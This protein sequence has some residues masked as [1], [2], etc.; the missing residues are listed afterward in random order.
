[1]QTLFL[2]IDVST[3]RQP[4]TYVALESDRRLMAIGQG[5][6]LEVLAFTAGQA[7][8][9]VAIAAPSRPNQGFMKNPE[10][11]N[12]LNPIPPPTKYLNLRQAE[13]EIELAGFLLPH[14]PSR[15]EN[16]PFWVKKAFSLYR[17]LEALGY[18][19]FPTEQHPR[20]WLETHSEAGFWCLGGKELLPANTLEGRLQRQL[21]LYEQELP[22]S[23]PMR[24]FE[25]VTRFRLL[26]GILPSE[27]ILAAAELSAM[28]AAYMAWLSAF[29]PQ[30]LCHYGSKEEGEIL[31]PAP[32]S[33]E[34]KPTRSEPPFQNK[35]YPLPFIDRRPER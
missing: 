7:S 29:Q 6:L 14:T 5:E 22:V 33:R 2:G 15:E 28:M 31:L 19:E 21:I 20:Q 18:Q 12:S 30:L 32:V 8:A 11:R 17:N 25:E 24:F 3:S 23:D 34:N 1:M 16:C 10:V 35:A 27:N 26:N 9:T 13:Y 4:F